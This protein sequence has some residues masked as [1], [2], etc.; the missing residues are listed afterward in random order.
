MEQLIDQ[1]LREYAGLSVL[2]RDKVTVAGGEA[3]H[4][5]GQ[6]AQVNLELYLLSSS[7]RSFLITLTTSPADVDRDNEIMERVARSFQ[8]LP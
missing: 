6:S 7:R 1:A 4:I 2:S 5:A 8:V 3:W